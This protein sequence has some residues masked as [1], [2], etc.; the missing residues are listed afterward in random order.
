MAF[1]ASSSLCDGDGVASNLVLEGAGHLV[2]ANVMTS[3]TGQDTPGTNG[4]RASL[5]VAVDFHANVLLAAGNPLHSG[6]FGKGVLKGDLLMSRCGFASLVPTRARHAKVL[7]ALNTVHGGVIILA[8]VALD[9]PVD[10]SPVGLGGLD[11]GVDEGVA[12]KECNSTK[13]GEGEGSTAL[14][15]AEVRRLGHG[16]ELLCLETAKAEGMQARKAAGVI[17]GLLAHR[18]LGQLVD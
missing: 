10:V 5:A 18:A 1:L 13:T 8:E 6:I 9:H 17:E 3:V 11:Q 2:Q 16:S 4:F 14:V 15:A 12:G 7:T